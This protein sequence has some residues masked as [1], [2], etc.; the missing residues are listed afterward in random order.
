M[1]AEKMEFQ[2][3][4]KQL[5]QLM[6]HSLYSHK[7]IFLRELISNAA[8]ALDKVRFLSLSDASVLGDDKNLGIKIHLEKDGNTVVI[9]DN[10][11]G[12]SREDLVNNLGTIA[13]SGTKKFMESLSGDAKQDFSLI[14]QFGVGFYSL[15]MVADKCE[16]STLRAGETQAYRWSSDGLG[17][18]T[19]EECDKSTRGTEIRIHL[20]DEDTEYGS[21]WKVRSLVRK[22]SEFVPHPIE[23]HWEAETG[24]DDAK[25]IENKSEVLNAKAAIWRRPKSELSEDQ[26]KEFY[27]HIA[28]EAEPLTWTHLK[29]EGTQEYHALLYIPTK[30][31]HGIF[32]AE[33]NHGVKLYVKRVFIMDEC[34]DLLP[35]WL[36]FAKGVVDSE[37]LPL[38]VSREILQNNKLVN[39][40]RKNLTKKILETL[41]DKADKDPEAYLA[42][43]KELGNVL[44][45]GFYMNWEHLDE[46]KELMRFQWSSGDA[47]SLT[48]LAQYK[49]AM[50]EGQKEIYF[51]S[52]ESRAAAESSPHLEIFKSKDIPVL[53]M[54][55][56]IDEWMLQGL[57]EYGDLKLRDIT[58]GELDLGELAKEEKEKAEENTGV[59][60]PLIE[61]I[62]SKLDAKIKDVR[63]SALLKDSPSRLVADEHD[64]SANMER[65]LKQMRQDPGS[66]GLGK[67]ILELNPEHPI[68]KHALYLAKAEVG[69][70][71]DWYNF[72]YQQALI[73]GGGELD[74][75]GEYARLVNKML[76]SK[77]G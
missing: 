41:K 65:L 61:A 21:E 9:S 50:K 75:P 42:W 70:A 38:N 43:W 55:D 35:N 4:V 7:E 28:H 5:L 77:L 74:N 27:E 18:Y 40:I 62:K 11:I 23:M 69:E 24:E 58:K 13:R 46:L 2:A 51:L 39:Q 52:A 16:V 36:R 26:Y 53:Y 49:E 54:V 76:A 29:A 66:M 45:E 14:G 15:F 47:S 60:K 63:I 19:I 59:F 37:D 6:I 31:P 17:E 67:K 73:S 3:E 32:Q 68:A 10:G 22:Y 25:I 72:L 20:K 33:A 57:N 71:E 48:S 1:S 64:M 44:K 8:D 12:M 34:K 56:P 30:A